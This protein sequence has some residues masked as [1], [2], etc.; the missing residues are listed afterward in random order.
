MSKQLLFIVSNLGFGGSNRSLQ[1]LLNKMD[2][3]LFRADVFALDNSGEFGIFFKKKSDLLSP[4]AFI[5]SLIANLDKQRGIQKLHS[6]IIK[7]LTKATRYNLQSY[8]FKRVANCLIT[9]KH[10][11]AVI[12]FGEG[13]P[14]FFVFSMN[15]PNKIAWIHSDYKS[16]MGFNNNKN[17]EKVYERFN[18]IVCVSE[19]TA[20]SFMSV[21]PN[22][23]QRVYAI[24]NI[25]DV[26]MMRHLSMENA[27]TE[28][29]KGKFNIVSIGR[30][31]PV[32]QLSIIPSIA[33]ELVGTGCD[34]CWYIIGPIGTK[35]EYEALMFN[36]KKYNSWDYVKILGEKK[37][38][39]CY[40]IQSDLLVNISKSEACPYVVNEAKILNTPVVCTNFG[41]AKEFI[42]YDV[43][44]YFEPLEKIADRIRFLMNNSDK[45]SAIKSALSTF[46]YDNQRILDQ[47]YQLVHRS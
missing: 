17:E 11:D 6:L 40:I 4:N 32:K 34:F 16:Y 20:K 38:P 27:E 1:N 2:S 9:Q 37:N 18:S 7:L 21:Y 33:S 35:A 15:H 30:L 39:Y 13:A 12:A 42:D 29:D 31:D 36:M 46:T 22:L 14:T 24:Y 43:N 23:K 5:H 26:D 3:S 8:L 45:Y 44:G 41:S 25:L 10:Y 47:F 19:F 28:F